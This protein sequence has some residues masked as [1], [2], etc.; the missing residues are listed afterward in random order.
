MPRPAACWPLVHAAQVQRMPADDVFVTSDA[1][2]P[3]SSI[4]KLRWGMGSAGRGN[5]SGAAGAAAPGACPR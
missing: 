3:F 4:G 2:T 5:A 1:R